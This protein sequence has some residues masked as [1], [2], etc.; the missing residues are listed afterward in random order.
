MKKI[1]Y[2]STYYTDIWNE[3]ALINKLRHTVKTDM[4]KEKI[5]SISYK[6]GVMLIN[7]EYKYTDVEDA[8][9]CVK[10]LLE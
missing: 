2:K 1:I 7:K 3:I 6:D 8:A 5:I 4:D 9:D 10:Y